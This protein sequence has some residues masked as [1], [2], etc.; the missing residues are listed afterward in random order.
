MS[1]SL[2][3]IWELGL[4]A[5][6]VRDKGTLVLSSGLRGWVAYVDLTVRRG[7]EYGM[8]RV[9][10]EHYGVL[11]R[12]ETRAF[13]SIVRIMDGRTS[14]EL[15]NSQQVYELESLRSCF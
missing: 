10:R 13:L 9:R 3:W 14:I 6:C 2:C 5:C 8:W 7:E 12:H 4:R 15:P 1:I 11:L